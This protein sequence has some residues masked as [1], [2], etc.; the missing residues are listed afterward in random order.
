MNE[1]TK[2][3]KGAV[4]LGDETLEIGVQFANVLKSEGYG[5]C[6]VSSDGLAIYA[7]L[8]DETPD[9][10]I[11]NAVMPNLDAVTLLDRWAQ[12]DSSVFFIVLSDTA[13]PFLMH[14]VMSHKNAYFSLNSLDP[15]AVVSLVTKIMKYKKGSE[16]LKNETVES[17][18]CYID[19]IEDEE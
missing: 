6:N 4:L 17:Y 11:I 10:A 2:K 1:E 3:I 8:Y 14:E 5:V 19:M 7:K 18:N 9:I 15:D 12:V 13:N 16:A